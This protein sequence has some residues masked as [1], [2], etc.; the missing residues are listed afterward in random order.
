MQSLSGEHLTLKLVRLKRSEE[1]PNQRHGFSFIL[2]KS[3]GGKYVSRQ[4]TQNLLPGDVLVLNSADEGI[5]TVADGEMVFWC[6]SVR[7]EH[8]FPLFAVGEICLLRD[9]AENLKRHMLYPASGLLAQECHR[10]VVAAPPP[11]TVDHRSHVLQVAAAVLSAEFKNARS[12]RVGFVRIEDHM[13]HVFEELSSNEL[14]TLSV[15][16]LA[17]KFSCSR[18]HLN[19]LFHQHFG[20]SVA[21]L[22]MEM[23][24]LTATSLLRDPDAKIIQVAEHCGF[25]HLGLFNACFKKRFGNTPSQWRKGAANGDTP[26]SDSNRGIPSC[27][28]HSNGMCPW[29][30][31]PAD[32]T[33]TARKTT[34]LQKTSFLNGRANPKLHE[35][36]FRNI[37]EVSTQM[38]YKPGFGTKVQSRP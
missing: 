26:V 31:T 9:T 36:V 23:R 20:C 13:M 34:P 38:K 1:W 2:P 5:I 18:R 10:L 3:G 29:T 24:L 19:R 37:R 8:L 33:A 17:R 15:G 28:L 21:S 7:F 22:R 30:P 11:G 12:Q 4:A 32:Y 6:F 16:E 25:N 14:L 35:T 27:P